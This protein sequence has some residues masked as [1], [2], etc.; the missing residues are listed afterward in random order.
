MSL[1]SKNLQQLQY[2]TLIL[3]LQFFRVPLIWII[4]SPDGHSSLVRQLG[5]N[6][7]HLTH[8][9]SELQEKQRDSSLGLH[10]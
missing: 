7:C 4:S 3:A 2:F 6:H 9:G 8:E 1:L 5:L 10:Y